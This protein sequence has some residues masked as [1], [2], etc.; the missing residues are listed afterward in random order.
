MYNKEKDVK[1]TLTVLKTAVITASAVLI[2]LLPV[3]SSEADPYSFQPTK[4]YRPDSEIFRKAKELISVAPARPLVIRDKDGN[5]MY[6][7]STGKVMVRVDKN[8]N[9]TFSIAGRKSHQRTKDGKLTKQWEQQ[10]GSNIVVEKNEFG[11]VLSYEE[12]GLGGK[13]LREYDEDFN[14]T[15]TYEYNKY[16]KKM[17]WIVDELTLTKTRFDSYGR[18]VYDVDYEGF[19]VAAF[20]YDDKGRLKQKTDV[21]GNITYFDRNGNMVKTEDNEGNLITTY[22]YEKDEKG[23]YTLSWVKDE[24]NGDMTIYNEEGRP[25]EVRNRQG[26]VIKTY[27]WLGTKLICTEDLE[28]DEVTWY[29]NGRRTYTTYKGILTKEWYY[30]EGKLAG[31]WDARTQQLELYTHGRKKEVFSLEGR[32]EIQQILEIAEAYGVE[33]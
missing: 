10:R 7:T 30:H 5:T 9:M 15:R 2:S 12:K 8:G 4:I 1:D 27:K 23:Y 33:I 3:Y 19:K 28:T 13:A 29:K 14:L 24:L 21:F 16:G 31:F 22:H 6:T 26:A 32:P 25:E 20:F 17:E 18:A 11:E